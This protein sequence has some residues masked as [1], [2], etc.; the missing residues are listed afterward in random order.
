VS[1]LK[2]S[3]NVLSDFFLETSKIIINFPCAFD[4]TVCEQIIVMSNVPELMFHSQSCDWNIHVAEL[5]LTVV[6]QLMNSSAN[7]LYS[8]M[9]IT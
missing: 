2:T 3:C 7:N 1:L 8:V 6:W 4:L 5:C 9:P